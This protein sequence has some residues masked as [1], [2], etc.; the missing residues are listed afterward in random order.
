[1]YYWR[2]TWRVD[3]EEYFTWSCRIFELDTTNLILAAQIIQKEIGDNTLFG[4]ERI[5][6]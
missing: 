4:L 1:M 2:A 5:N 6:F 3:T